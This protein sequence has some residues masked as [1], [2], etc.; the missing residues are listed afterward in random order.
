MWKALAK[1]LQIGCSTKVQCCGNDASAMINNGEK[2]VSLYCFRCGRQ[3]WEPH[4]PRSIHEIMATRRAVEV[5]ERA[6]S[7]PHDAL[8]LMDGPPEALLWVLSGGLSPEM[9]ND[10]YGFRYEPNVRLVLI[11][12]ENGVLGRDVFGGKP[13]Y[14]LFGDGRSYRLSKGRSGVTVVVEDILSAIAVN[15]AGWTSLAVLGTSISSIQATY[16]ANTVTVG[17]FDNDAAGD[18]AYVRLRKAMGLH[19][20]QVVRIQT[21]VD[22]KH[23]HREQISNLIGEAVCP[24]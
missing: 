8:A 21:D 20:S 15:R 24:F 18:A 10:V 4:G 23:I 19:P 17:W 2:G 22:P 9:A 3:E 13:K 12:I 16:A 1:K 6:A 7:M 5:I 14:R 11:P